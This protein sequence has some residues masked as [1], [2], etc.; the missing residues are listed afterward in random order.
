VDFEGLSP[1]AK[2]VD[3][4]FTPAVE[5]LESF[6]E[7]LTAVALTKTTAKEAIKTLE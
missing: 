6:G 1:G 4:M 3:L 2:S 7:V 5:R